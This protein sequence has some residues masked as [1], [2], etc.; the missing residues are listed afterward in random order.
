[1]TS[2]DTFCLLTTIDIREA[3]LEVAEKA[4]QMA[5]IIATPGD[6]KKGAKLFQVSTKQRP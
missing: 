1:M 6:A 4:K 5:N 3:E 2:F